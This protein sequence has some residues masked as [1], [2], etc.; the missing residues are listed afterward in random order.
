M[1]IGPLQKQ[2]L[3]LLDEVLK[4]LTNGAGREN[5]ENIQVLRDQLSEWAARV[6]VIGQVKAG[7]ST[8]LNA[9]LHETDF[10]PSDVNPWTSVVTNIRINIKNDPRVG[11]RFDFF[12]EADWD[13]I[14][15]GTSEVRELTE[16]MLPGFDTELLRRQA[17]EMRERAQRRLGENYHKLLGQSHEFDF[18][19]SDLMQRY[20][21]AGQ[22]N[23]PEGDTQ[24]QY[25]LITKVANA[26][27]RRPEFKVPVILTDTPGVN[28][29][30][31]VRD[32]FTCRSLDNSDVFVVVLSAHQPLT[33]V[34]IALIRLLAKQDAKEVII[35]VN[36]IDELDDYAS[37]VPHVINDV[38]HRLRKAVPEIE[39]TIVA[40]S[41]YMAAMAKRNDSEAAE[42]R[43]NLD[44]P[45]LH[46]YLESTLGHVPD[47]QLER[48]LIGSGLD[49]MKR[50]LSMVIDNGVGSHKLAKLFE[51]TRAEVSAMTFTA[52][53]ERESV[54]LQMERL[55]SENAEGALQNLEDEIAG[56]TTMQEGLDRL[57][58]AGDTGLEQ[59][60]EK[61]WIDLEQGLNHCISNFLDQQREVL[62]EQVLRQNLQGKTKKD[63]RIDLT[64]LH[65]NFDRQIASHYDTARANIDV[66]LND[67]LSQC[68]DLVS[69]RFATLPEGLTLDDL[70]NY[71]FAS[72][73]AFSKRELWV[74]P[75]NDKNWMFWRRKK[76]NANKS[77]EAFRTIAA[78]ELRPVVAKIINAFNE[79]QV[80]R[81]ATG[82]ERIRVLLRMVENASNER[83]RRLRRDRRQM[84]QTVNDASQSRVVADRLHS[85]L[86][87][88]ERRVQTLA[89]AEAALAR[90]AL[91]HAA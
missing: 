31:L 50:I 81:A 10:L 74:T 39:F 34:D 9:F 2:E 78:A 79:A 42:A 84:E 14:I 87:V 58:D 57:V 27:M 7:K 21:C 85:Q 38:S 71:E 65:N 51:D 46:D 33:N 56:L 48:L 61:S 80:D 91:S 88:L 49:E 77:F 70:P 30:F 12:S 90:T 82:S 19:N 4:S 26:Y 25:A 41:A 15:N 23:G 59:V 16:K 83:A 68:L 60:L 3:D 63:L 18:L 20:V 72:T 64:E 22:D 40:G 55:G 36:R 17:D 52:K 54:Q 28:D 29:P 76:I 47:D 62:E 45:E 43:E 66:T 24:G 11:A 75:V 86:E 8:F 37:E 1:E 73:L 89:A 35:F 67:S 44:T 53:R 69:H 13:E 6:A 32:E 5:R